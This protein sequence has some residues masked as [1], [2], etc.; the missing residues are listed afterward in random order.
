MEKQKPIFRIETIED[1]AAVFY[2]QVHL[3]GD[4]EGLFVLPLGASGEVLS[5]P[6]MVSL[7]HTKGTTK[8]RLGD[9]FAAVNRANG[10]AFI[11]AH[12]HPSGN[13][14]PSAADHAFTARLKDAAALLETPQFLDHL[15]IGSL[16]ETG[17]IS[18][19]EL[20]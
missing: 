5:A 11:V 4:D 18:L 9:I 15:I 7:G 17:F 16:P 8:I 14:T 3:A 20:T 6:V 19:E 13:L 1:A 2:T 12:N 10:A